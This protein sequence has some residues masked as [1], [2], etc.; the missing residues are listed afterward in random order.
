MLSAVVHS[1]IPED[2][3][4]VEVLQSDL[5]AE[6]PLYIYHPDDAEYLLYS[7]SI[8]LL[9][10]DPRVKK[11]LATS[12]EGVSFL[13]QS[14]VIPP[15]KTIYRDIY[16]LGIGDKAMVRSDG[17]KIS[18][19]FDHDFPFRN[20][21]R[22]SPDE[23]TPDEDQILQ[24]VAEATISRVD[25]SRPTFLFHS[26]GKDSN[27]IA[28]ALA[29]AGWQNRVSLITHKSTGEKDES[30]ISAHIA[31][32]LGFSHCVLHGKVKP[33]I[34]EIKSVKNYF[35]EAPL[36]STDKVTLAYPFYSH[37]VPS[38]EGANLI[39]GMGNDVYIGHI[40]SDH[41][42]EGQRRS[43]FLQKGRSV[44]KKFSSEN[45]WSSA[46]RSRA[47]W[48]GL[49]GFSLADSQAIFPRSC[50]VF[51]YWKSQDRYRD[52]LDLRAFVRGRV[53]DQEV[54]IRKVR[55]FSDVSS[56]NLVLP[57]TNPRVAEYFAKM[58]EQ[59]LYDRRNLKN[60]LILRE[61]LKKRIGL[62][63]DAIGKK[64][65]SYDYRALMKENWDWFM[66]EIRSCRFWDKAGLEM[67]LPRLERAV[68]NGHRRAFM[69]EHLI[70]RLYLISAWF[71][72]N[73]YVNAEQ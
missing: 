56:S 2:V 48:C 46:T 64:G 8:Q 69:A 67:V 27:T 6:F 12:D 16:V 59:Y 36:P 71:N 61:L 3:N 65:F 66:D 28:L 20:A 43:S 25:P 26:A 53:V 60:K 54:F 44:A 40:P 4:G 35:T 17:R 31:R 52:Y 73:K 42:Y 45:I 39:D 33:S 1:F 15:P 57:F 51:P 14:G 21:E 22:L 49:G 55:N 24:L 30:G 7:R 5:A 11:P 18:L 29:E 37:Q 72:H 58:P 13:L 34:D 38:L 47:E 41:E 23:M 32:K 9:L 70:Y 19:E 62:D 68:L 50:D 63:S 10:E